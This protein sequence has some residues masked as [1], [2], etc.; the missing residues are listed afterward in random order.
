MIV[1]TV[2]Q[3]SGCCGDVAVSGGSTAGSRGGVWGSPLFLNQSEA[4]RTENFFLRSGPPLSQGLDDRPPP[5]SEG[6]D[7]PL[8][9]NQFALKKE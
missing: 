7:P 5:L 3:K 4:R 9:C 8:D 1:R 6:V 2:R